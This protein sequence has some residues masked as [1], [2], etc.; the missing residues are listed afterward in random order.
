MKNY[1][2]SNILKHIGRFF[3]TRSSMM[4]ILVFCGASAFSVILRFGPGWGLGWGG[5]VTSHI[6][7]YR[8]VRKIGG[9]FFDLHYKYWCDNL[10][11]IV[12]VDLNTSSHL[13]SLLS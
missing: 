11:K 8:D 13:I 7:V 10:A 2:Q 3:P 1:A 4:K 5:G 9:G 6:E 12:C